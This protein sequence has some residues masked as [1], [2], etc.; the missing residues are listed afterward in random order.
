MAVQ[1][2]IFSPAQAAQRLGLKVWRVREMLL[3]GIL[4]GFRKGLRQ[5]AIPSE[6]LEKCINSRSNKPQE[7]VAS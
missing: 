2:I 1:Q 6:D 7:A 5:W 4:P 3:E